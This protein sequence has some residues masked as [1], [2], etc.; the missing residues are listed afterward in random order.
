MVLQLRLYA[1]YN[2]SK[3]VMLFVVSLFVAEILSQTAILLY[4]IIEAESRFSGCFFGHLGILTSVVHQST[5]DLFPVPPHYRRGSV[6]ALA[7]E[8]VE[9]TSIGYRR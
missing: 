2:R 3:K 9:F 7:W 5:P 8:S 1:L 6:F 4:G